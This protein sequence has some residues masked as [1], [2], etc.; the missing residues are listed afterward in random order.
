VGPVEGEKTLQRWFNPAA[1][2]APAAGFYGNAGT[3][4]IRGPGE[5]SWNVG[6]FKN[7]PLAERM[8]LQFRVEAFNVFNTPSFRAVSTAFGAGNF[9]QVTSAAE[10]RILE[11]ALK[12]QF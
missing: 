3:G 4:L 9:G 12:F 8:K 5:Q 2:A 6:L 10:P 11:F 1:F 7:F